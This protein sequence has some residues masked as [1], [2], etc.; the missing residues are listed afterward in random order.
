MAKFR[1]NHSKSSKGKS[2]ALRGF[3][4]TGILFL[5]LFFNFY[6]YASFDEDS[7]HNDLQILSDDEINYLPTGSSSQIIRHRYYSLAYNENN[8]QAD[9]VAYKLTKQSIQIPNVKREREYRKDYKVKTGSAIHSDY[10]H[11][12]YTRGHL[13]PAGDMAFNTTAMKESFFMSNMTPQIRAFNNGIWKELE[14]NTRDWA[15]RNDEIYIV[16][17]PLFNLENPTQIGKNNVA[18]PDAF[19]KAILDIKSPSQKSI[20][21]IVPHEKSDIHLS[22][23]A[24]SIDYLE[25]VCSF[26]LFPDLYIDEEEEQELESGMDIKLYDYRIACTR[27]YNFVSF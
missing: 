27:H 19:Y 10:S 5:L 13:A 12:G 6:K 3:M 7:T 20:A 16:S 25:N 8:E 15:Y 14:E 24:V 18:V 9:W 11:S 2:F 1:K 17:G 26:N 21:F 4:V 22:E 23:Y